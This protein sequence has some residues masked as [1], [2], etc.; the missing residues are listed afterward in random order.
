MSMFGDLPAGFALSL[1]AKGVASRVNYVAR[2]DGATQHW[3]LS[4]PITAEDGDDF[5]LKIKADRGVRTAGCFLMT[6]MSGGDYGIN[7][8][9][10]GDYSTGAGKLSIFG[11]GNSPSVENLDSFTNLDVEVERVSGVWTLTVNGVSDTKTPTSEPP[12]I[13][14][15]TATNLGR[16]VSG[17]FYSDG[18][19]SDF[20]FSKNG[21]V[22]NKIPLT[23]KPQ[24]ATQLATVGS[25]N[26]TMINY[27]EAV[28]EEV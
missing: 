2:L 20:E 5:S 8:Y 3:E 17:S 14:S 23:N 25:V 15:S 12:A 24:G 9:S 18:Y 10:T 11:L 26:A 13:A 27:T 19:I 1:V 7:I 28:W 21:V 4:E 16:R 6:S 22:I